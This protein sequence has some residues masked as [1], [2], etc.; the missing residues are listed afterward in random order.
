[1]IPTVDGMERWWPRLVDGVIA[2]LVLLA[3]LAE[4]WVP[5]DSRSGEGSQAWSTV[6]VLVMSGALLLRRVQPLLCALLVGTGLMAFHLAD[7]VFLLFQGQFVPLIL[8]T[9]AVARYGRGRSP[10]VGGAALG[11]TLVFADLT[12]EEFQE[13]SEMIFHWGVLG[14]VYA[15]G[16]WQRVMASREEAAR[17]RAIAAEVEA[18]EKAAAAVLEE[19]TRIARE[20]HDVVAHAMSVMVVQAG[21]AAGVPDTPEAVRRS[22]GSIRETGAGALAEMRRLVT[23]LR[24]PDEAAARAPQPGLDAVEVLVAEA[25]ETG[26]PVTLTALGEARDLPAGLD[27][28]AYRIVQEALTNARRHAVTATTVAVTLDFTGDE[29]RIDV[30][31]D[32]VPSA[33]TAG[34]GHGLIGMRERVQLY[35]GRM[36]AGALPG[37]GFAVEAALPL[38]HA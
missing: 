35:G 19:R 37:R 21:A 8:A 31:D 30:R 26:L 28:A 11:A 29:L 36:R 24:D 25:R 20:L 7:V 32:G 17:R 22:L 14:S 6:Q 34:S 5:L 9:F 2:L 15:L 10:Y 1:M 4:I 3:A 13:P 16:T 27:L 33:D 12:I 23:M 18:A 38:E